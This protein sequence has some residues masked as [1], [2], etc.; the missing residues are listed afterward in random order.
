MSQSDDIAAINNYITGSKAKTPEAERIKADWKSWY[1]N[2]SF[3]Q[4]SMDDDTLM[5]ANAKR[6]AFN[7]ANG[8]PKAPKNAPPAAIIAKRLNVDSN[9]AVRSP[10]QP[11]IARPTLRVGS[12]GKDV[13]DWQRKLGIEK[14]DGKFGP[15]TRDMTKE[16]QSK[17]GLKSDG[18]VGP[19][20]WMAAYVTDPSPA[21]IPAEVH[22]STGALPSAKAVETKK[23]I[24]T[25]A[26]AVSKKIV[27]QGKDL[28]TADIA[29]VTRKTS[30]FSTPVKV[31]AVA[32][33]FGGAWYW[34]KGRK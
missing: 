23:A 8:S 15:K 33:I 29:A 12:R 3:W 7:V 22:D 16:W 24:L 31:G 19:A 4:Q 17:H 6:E 5:N 34:L 9:P 10:T 11:G 14:V 28:A 30:T 2:L 27:A 32:A 13:E 21:A 20:T 1:S 26:V 25:H 18:V